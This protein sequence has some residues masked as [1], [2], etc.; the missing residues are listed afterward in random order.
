MMVG[1][2]QL[3][4]AGAAAVH[5]GVDGSELFKV[6]GENAGDWFGLSVSGAG[7]LD[8]DGHADVVVGAS[9]HDPLNAAT[10]KLLKDAGAVYAYSGA[11]GSRLFKAPGLAAGDW[12]GYSVAA[13]GDLDNDTGADIVAGAPRR[14]RTLPPVGRKK[15]KVLRDVGAVY[16]LDGTGAVLFSLVGNR[17]KDYYGLSLASAGDIDLDGYADIITATPNADKAGLVLVGKK[18]KAKLIKDIGLIE[19]FSG[20]VATGN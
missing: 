6:A 1:L 17:P 14:D 13:G 18:M 12:L 20:K 3:K 7:D 16:G 15:A 4:D 10:G 9:R 5:S 2:G 8:G 19:V 11:D